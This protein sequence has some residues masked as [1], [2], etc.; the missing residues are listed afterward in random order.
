[1]MLS[2]RNRRRPAALL[3]VGLAAAISLVWLASDRAE[4]EV[5]HV[6]EANTTSS[7]EGFQW[8]LTPPEYAALHVSVPTGPNVPRGVQTVEGGPQATALVE[9]ATQALAAGT[10][11]QRSTPLSI[12]AIRAVDTTQDGVYLS[13]TV[14]LTLSSTVTIDW[15]V[16]PQLSGPLSME[17]IDPTGTF[18]RVLWDGRVEVLRTTTP[19]FT[20]VLAVTADGWMAS[21]SYVRTGGARAP[22]I[23]V[24]TS[25]LEAALRAFIQVHG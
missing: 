20:Q 7:A 17:A 5:T 3:S 13:S 6:T 19:F 25:E 23:R 4:T 16:V 11:A 9:S 22:D 24:Q 14:L 21:I 18:D 12:R 2:W 15:T 1:M 8:L 10:T